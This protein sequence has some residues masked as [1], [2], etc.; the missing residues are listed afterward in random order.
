MTWYCIYSLADNSIQGT[1]GFHVDDSVYA[2]EGRAQFEIQ[3][4]TNTDGMIVDTSSGQPIL[5]PV[6]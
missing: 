6:S 2:A 1:A 4:G 3:D 5:V